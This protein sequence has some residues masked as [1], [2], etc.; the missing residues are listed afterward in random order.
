MSNT[1]HERNNILGAGYAEHTQPYDMYIE[2]MDSYLFRI[3]NEGI[4]KYTSMDADN[5]EVL[6]AGDFIIV[7]PGR[8]Y[9]LMINPQVQLDQTKRVYS[10]D[11]FLFLK[12][13]WIDQW[14]QKMERPS[15]L[16][17]PLNQGIITYFRQ[18]THEHLRRGDESKEICDHL[19]K[20]LCLTIDCIISNQLSF[21][22]HFFIAC[23]MKQFIEKNITT[24]FKVEDVAKHVNLS[25]SRTTTLFKMAFGKSIIQYT[26]DL[27]LDIARE[28]IMLGH[29]HLQHLA[30]SCGFQNYNYFYKVFKKK[31]NLSPKEFRTKYYHSLD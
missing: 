4:A 25:V 1:S 15:K 6:K 27:R 5:L 2:K 30:E 12:G 21:N 20:A 16:K 8:P 3:Q 13:A 26:L 17:V 19:S 31:F 28:R 11:Y 24:P 14:A 29:Y 23:Q 22:G 9:R 10:F 7:P 18:L